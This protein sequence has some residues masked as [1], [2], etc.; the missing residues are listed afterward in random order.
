MV[1]IL[2]LI[3]VGL[4]YGVHVIARYRSSAM[5][6]T[7]KA[8]SAASCTAVQGNLI[9]AVTTSAVFLMALLTS[10]QG[11]ASWGS[12]PGWVSCSASWR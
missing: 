6:T 8:R 1:F 10:F 2:V 3:G 9:G 5:T 11:C 12:S 7:W 4:D